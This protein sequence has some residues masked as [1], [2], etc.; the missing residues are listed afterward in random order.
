MAHRIILTARAPEKPKFKPL[1]N[2]TKVQCTVLMGDPRLPDAVKRNGKFNQED[3]DTVNQLKE[4]LGGL[5][6]FQFSYLDHHKTLIQKFLQH[7][8]QFVMNLCDE[9]WKND[10]FKELHPT[11]LM[12]MLEI[13]F[14]GAGPECLSICYNKSTVCS[15]AQS[16]GIATPSEIWIDPSSHSGA[17]PSV[18]PAILKPA[19]GD[20]SIGITQHAVVHSSEEF[21]T[22][23]DTLKDQLPDVPILVQEFLEGREFSIGLIGNGTALDVLPVLEV[24]YSKLPKQ[25]PKIL[26][27]ESKW[28]LDSPY[29][30]KIEYHR[31]DIDDQTERTMVDAATSLFH[32]LKCRDYARFDFRMDLHG[33]PKLLEVNPNP[34]WCWDGKMALMA[35]HAGLS[36]PALDAILK[37][38]LQRYPRFHE[39]L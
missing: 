37:A 6:T 36:Y 3:H 15:I 38:A 18:F 28:H 35:K 22:Y 32:R 29:C 26:G 9:G 20:S 12:E 17:I 34:G 19:Y 24:D 23:F 2:R 5:S 33:E 39:K 7:P 1:K 10:P 13:P 31:A 4:A 27:Y 21:V 8:P 30:T 14:S 16:M 11:A 25:L